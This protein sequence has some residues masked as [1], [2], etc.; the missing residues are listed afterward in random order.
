MGALEWQFLV[1]FEVVGGV[2]GSRVAIFAGFRGGQ[3][4]VGALE[5]QFLF[6]DFEVVGGVRGSRVASFWCIV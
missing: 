4:R 3:W 1:D 5:W 2:G 6:D